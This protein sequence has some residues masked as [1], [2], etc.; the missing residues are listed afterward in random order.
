MKI[1]ELLKFSESSFLPAR[2]LNQVRTSLVL[3]LLFGGVGALHG[4]V[5]A[6]STLGQSVGGEYMVYVSGSPGNFTYFHA[7]QT[8]TT[9]ASGGTLSGISVSFGTQSFSNNT[10]SL[11]LYSNGSG[12]PGGLIET[13]SGSAQPTDGVFSYAS[14]GSTVLAPNTTYWW[15]ASSS[16]NGV[17]FRPQYEA[18]ATLDAGTSLGWTVGDRYSGSIRNSTSLPT[19][20][21]AGAT[22][23]LFSVSLVGSP[24]PEPS[25]FALLGGLAAFAGAALRRRP[26]AL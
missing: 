14:G 13:L 8:F 18:S 12:Q 17:I 3:G 21:S 10:F 22:P 24:V 23:F 6:L 7:A 20:A 1:N 15:V 4:E 11:R 2:C 5:V 25:S 9:G 16:T 19:F 26:R